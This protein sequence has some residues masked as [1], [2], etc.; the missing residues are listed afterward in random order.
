MNAEFSNAREH[1]GKRLKHT[2]DVVC[3]VHICRVEARDH[4]IETGLLIFCKGLI[5]HRDPGI[6]ERVVVQRSVGVQVIRW[7][8]VTIH[9]IGPLLLQWNAEQRNAPH[10]AA[11]HVKKVVDVTPLLNVVGKMKVN[12][13]EFGP[14]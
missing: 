14:F 6:R 5:G 10:L 12:V 4:R 2:T 8:A 1:A 3:G 9:S 11:H 13:V 7:G